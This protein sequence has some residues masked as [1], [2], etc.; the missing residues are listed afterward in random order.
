M[1]C[2]DPE[3]PTFT[4]ISQ[5]DKDFILTQEKYSY[6]PSTLTVDCHRTVLYRR[7]PRDPFSGPS[8]TKIPV[9]LSGVETHWL[10]C[11][12]QKTVQRGE[13]CVGGSIHRGRTWSW[14]GTW[15]QWE[16]SGRGRGRSRREWWCSPKIT[17]TWS[18]AM[19][20]HTTDQRRT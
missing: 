14:D 19:T 2:M 8:G 4:K 18:R 3:T 20:S 10:R 6:C 16:V 12:G 5:S 9:P 15:C 17:E 1:I 11:R 13:E 7:K